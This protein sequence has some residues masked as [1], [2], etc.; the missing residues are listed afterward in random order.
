MRCRLAATWKYLPQICL[1]LWFCS[2][3][4][5]HIPHCKKSINCNFSLWKCQQTGWWKL[6][7]LIIV[8][9]FRDITSPTVECHNS[10]CALSHGYSGL[11]FGMRAVGGQSLNKFKCVRAWRRR[12]TVL[13]F[14]PQL[15]TPASS[16][17]C[18]NILHL[19]LFSFKWA[20]VEKSARGHVRELERACQRILALWGE[21]SGVLSDWPAL[22]NVKRKKEVERVRKG[23]KVV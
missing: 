15:N 3:N 17:G 6:W 18:R 7:A 12:I 11:L 4:P 5:V 13:R 1:F 8:G 23:E 22:Q 21:E 20:Y 16:S 19:S 14:M 10:K 9:P 2:Y